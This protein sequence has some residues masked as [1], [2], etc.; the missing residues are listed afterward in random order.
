MTV[1]ALALLWSIL[2]YSLNAAL[3]V[4]LS[5]FLYS[6]M[7]S[8]AYADMLRANA[9]KNKHCNLTGLKRTTWTS[10]EILVLG[11]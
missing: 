8:A 5:F 3:N 7:A 10:C 11:S 4:V 1:I 2:S 9:V 6:L